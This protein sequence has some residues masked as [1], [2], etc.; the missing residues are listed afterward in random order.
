MPG[1]PRG[2][3]T[4]ETQHHNKV[5]SKYSNK[6]YRMF[7]LFGSMGPGKVGKGFREEEGIWA[8]RKGEYK[9]LTGREE[10]NKGPDT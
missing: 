3:E 5:V 10:G 8:G 7:W 1:I 6:I 2:K 4:Y 9:F